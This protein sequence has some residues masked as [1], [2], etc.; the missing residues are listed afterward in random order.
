M[1]TNKYLNLGY[2]SVISVVFVIAM[3]VSSGFVYA[4]SEN[5]EEIVLNVEGMTCGGCENAIKSA[6]LK[7][8]GVK[9]AEVNYKDGTAV[10]QTEGSKV[11]TDELIKAIEKAGFTASK[12]QYGIGCTKS[13]LTFRARG[14]QGKGF[15]KV[16]FSELFCGVIIPEWCKSSTPLKSSYNSL[17]IINNVL[18][19]CKILSKVKKRNGG[20]LK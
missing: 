13:K 8:D 10:V 16:T 3:S 9:D 19:M 12:S 4:G 2:L 14:L 18:R 15:L 11:E 1:F 20:W 7:C 17:V 6:L 5:E